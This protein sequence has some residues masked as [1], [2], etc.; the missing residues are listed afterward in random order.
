MMLIKISMA[1][2][3]LE[4]KYVSAVREEGE[5]RRRHFSWR[6]LFSVV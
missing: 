5:T 3:M 6:L 1:V 2:L 4:M